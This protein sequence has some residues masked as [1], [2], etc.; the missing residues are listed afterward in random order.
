MLSSASVVSQITQ[1]NWIRGGS[2]VVQVVGGMFK[3]FVN[4]RNGSAGGPNVRGKGGLDFKKE[5]HP[6]LTRS[7]IG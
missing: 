5:V 3:R 7:A 2:R 4:V 1:G 6:A